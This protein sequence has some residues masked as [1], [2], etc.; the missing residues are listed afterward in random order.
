MKRPT[1]SARTL[2]TVVI[3]AL[4]VGALAIHLPHV[5][6]AAPFAA[7]AAGDSGGGAASGESSAHPPN[8]TIAAASGELVRADT[9]H[10]GETLSELLARDGVKP[11]RV[12]R[13]LAA[14]TGI[15]ERRVPAGLPVVVRTARADSVPSEVTFQLAVD[16]LIHVR[17][18]ADS[19]WT[20]TEE[21][22]PWKTDTLAVGGAI[23]SNLYAALD[24]SAAAVLP[25]GARSEL[26]WSLADIYEYRVD[27]SRDLQPGDTFR[28]LFE[29]LIGPNG[30]V[31]VGRVLAA[32]FELSG[33]KTDAVRFGDAKGIAQYFDQTGRSMRAAFLRV[34]LQFRRISSVFGLRMHPILGIMRE[35]TGIDYA[36][37]AGT[38]VRAIGDGV[39]TF[40]GRRGGYGNMIDIRHRNGFVSRYGHLRGF[41]AGIRAGRQVTIGETIG[42]VGMT[43]L[44][45]GPHLHFEILVN[46]TQRDPRTAL[47]QNAGLPIATADR[48]RFDSV[49]SALMALLKGGVA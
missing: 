18:A 22:L 9:L 40:A 37:N 5:H 41:A 42:Y 21:R 35:H 6:T 32:R 36:A 2:T 47:K 43:G 33:T 25:K 49:K 28:V 29:R 23:S 1:P 16:H 7:L 11:S 45:T 3:V 26:A 44:A 27:M 15:D 20:A 12:P 46:G 17:R 14:A 19:T 13:I 48:V 10:A 24:D 31:K 34:P 8:G 30:V 4:G 39:V 38:P